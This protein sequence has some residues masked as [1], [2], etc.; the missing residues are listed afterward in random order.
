MKL[1]RDVKDRRKD[2]HNYTGSKSRA[3]ENVGL[4]L[5]GGRDLMT[6]GMEEAEMRYSKFFFFCFHWL[7]LLSDCLVPTAY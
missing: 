5:N 3:E 2:F 7:D 4:V 6:Q 1:A